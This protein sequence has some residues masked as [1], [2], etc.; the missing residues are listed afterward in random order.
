ME[1]KL[2]VIRCKDIEKSKDFYEKL[3]FNF[4]KE[5]HG[6]GPIHYSCCVGNMVLELYPLLDNCIDNIRLGFY[7]DI[8]NIDTYLSIQNIEIISTYIFNNYKVYVIKDPDN[9]KIELYQ[10]LKYVLD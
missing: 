3:K 9:R 6:K 7:I 5:Q 2:L 4:K 8:D 1:L 10:E